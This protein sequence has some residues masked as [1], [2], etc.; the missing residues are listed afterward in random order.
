M[1]ILF[2]VDF[3]SAPDVGRLPQNHREH[4]SRMNKFSKTFVKKNND[5]CRWVDYSLDGKTTL[6][7]PEIFIFFWDFS[8]LCLPTPPYSYGIFL[9]EKSYRVQN[10]HSFGNW[11]FSQR[12]T[13]DAQK[14]YACKFLITT[15]TCHNS[16]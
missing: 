11:N 5:S 14:E 12:S 10:S 13:S 4:F 16:Y 8:L 7:L 6:F 15:V 3:R 1:V 2:S 9:C